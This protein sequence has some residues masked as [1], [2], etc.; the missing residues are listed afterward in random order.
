[1]EPVSK[2]RVNRVGSAGAASGMNIVWITSEVAPYAKTGGL[3]D[4]SATLPASMARDGHNV[5]VIMPYYPQSKGELCKKIHPLRHNL[6]VPF[7]HAI[8]SASIHE[9]RANPNLCFYF[10][11]FNRYFDRP[12]IYDY[13][14]EEYGDNAERYIFFSR[15]SMQV[16]EELELSPDILHCHDWHSALCSVYLKSH[17]YKDS[18]QFSKCRSVL[19]I[20]NL[21]YQGIFHKDNMNLTQL[22]WDYFNYTC[23]EYYDQINLL[24]GG[25]MC[26]DRVNTVSPTYAREIQCPGYAFNLESVLGHAEYKGKLCGILNGIDTREWNPATDTQIPANYDKSDLTGK[27]K[28]KT[29]LQAEMQLKE[30][31]E[32]PVLGVISRLVYQKGIDVLAAIAED[33][34]KYEDIHFAVLGTGESRLESRLS[35]LA[36]KYPGRFGVYIGYNNHLAHLI[37]AGSDFFAMPSRYEPCG[38]NQMY[39]MRYGAVPIVRHTGG[40]ADTVVNYDPKKLSNSTGFSFFDLDADPLYKTISWA[41]SIY[42]KK[43]EHIRKLMINGMSRDFSWTRA[44]GE[45][46]KLYM[47]T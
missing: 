1:M 43:P 45:Y 7:G 25:I 2:L 30:N 14:G 24:K 23:L 34:L 21:A 17:L 33:L 42:R 4:I 9:D 8:E 40:L 10:I 35:D 3:A 19:T 47:D 27:R 29:C 15:A 32:I 28:C 12:F 41:L 37:E 39:S 6:Q 38:L 22:G 44:A 18:P 11:E 31:P 16:I 20:H 13:Y 26:A 46:E 36:A 5:S